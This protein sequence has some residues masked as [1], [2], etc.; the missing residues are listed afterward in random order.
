[1]APVTD[2]FFFPFLKSYYQTD[3]FKV[4]QLAGDASNRRYY[5]VLHNNQSYVLM[6][7]EPFDPENYPFLSVLN[8]FKKH[9]VHVPEVILQSPKEGL[10]LLEDLGDLTLE[11]KFWENQSQEHSMSAYKLA[12]DEILKIHFLATRDR[13][14]CTAFNVQFDTEKLLWEMKYGMDNLLIGLCNFPFTEATKAELMGT[15]TSLCERLHREPKYIAHRDY[16]SRNLMIKH[17][18]MCVIDFQD[19]R[20]GAIQYDLVSLL[21]D[22]YVNMNDGMA[23]QLLN[24]YLENAKIY[25]PRDFSRTHFD[26]IY[27]VQTIQRCFKACGSF[28]SFF[29]LRNDRRY[30]KYIAHTL[31]LVLKSLSD[32]PEYKLMSNVLIDSGAL[33]K[34]Y[35]SL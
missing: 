23:N 17:D 21:R 35:E 12:I 1:M 29:H 11:R 4:F 15:F 14:P 30:L 6:Q 32:F 3:D 18:R 7:W 16:H 13:S 5:R 20:M 24:Y 28:A 19:A 33:E 22:S 9:Q 2:E 26:V 27:E 34:K 8:H 25:L 10:V 31:R